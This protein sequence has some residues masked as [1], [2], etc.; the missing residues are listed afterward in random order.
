MSKKIYEITDEYYNLCSEVQNKLM[1]VLTQFGGDSLDLSGSI[2]DNKKVHGVMLYT[3]P[4]G[5]HEI[6][7]SSTHGRAGVLWRPIVLENLTENLA[8]LIDIDDQLQKT[9]NG[10]S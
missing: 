5:D 4:N 10:D 2:Y 8:L 6:R 7:I 3:L 1:E 9:T